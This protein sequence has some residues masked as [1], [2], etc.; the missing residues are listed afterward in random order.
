MVSKE[1]ERTAAVIPFGPAN[2][3]ER[4]FKF[5]AWVA[6]SH[7]P[8]FYARATVRIT[9]DQFGRYNYKLAPH[10]EDP[11]RI[12]SRVKDLLSSANIHFFPFKPQKPT[13]IGMPAALAEVIAK[14]YFAFT[15]ID[16]A[17]FEFMMLNIAA[18][19]EQR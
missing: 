18:V 16:R 10:P 4:E 14:W 3:D 11:S 7:A 5:G 19:I 9:R 13:D 6:F 8:D 17:T 15:D 2:G 1:L 12:R